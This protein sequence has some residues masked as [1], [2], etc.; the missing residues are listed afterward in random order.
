MNKGVSHIVAL[1]AAMALA[2]TL[3]GCGGEKAP[4]PE[5]TQAA[6]EAED[7]ATEAEEAEEAEA[8]EPAEEAEEF[9]RNG[10]GPVLVDVGFFAIDLPEGLKYSIRSSYAQGNTL[11]NSAFVKKG[12]DEVV[13]IEVAAG[14]MV[15]SVG[16]AKKNVDGTLKHYTGKTLEKWTEVKLAGDTYQRIIFH[17]EHYSKPDAYLATYNKGLDA[18]IMLKVPMT[19]DGKDYQFPDELETVMKATEFKKP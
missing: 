3:A 5:Q 16:D 2:G 10:E 15:H 14:A 12:N 18:M 4:A 1:L 11:L 8:E 6:V 7:E 17:S 13:F 19:K 9:P